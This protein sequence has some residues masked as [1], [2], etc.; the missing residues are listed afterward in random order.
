MMERLRQLRRLEIL[1]EFHIRFQELPG[2]I[3]GGSPVC[4]STSMDSHIRGSSQDVIAF[5]S[6]HLHSTVNYGLLR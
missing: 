6:V 3:C 1:L 4:G 2:V 5:H